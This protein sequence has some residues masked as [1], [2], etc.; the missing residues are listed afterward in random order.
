MVPL[1]SLDTVSYFIVTMVLSSVVFEIK[2]DIGRKSRFLHT[3]L[4][5]A[6]PG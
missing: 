4:F 5:D 2:R 6:R 1:E 3:S